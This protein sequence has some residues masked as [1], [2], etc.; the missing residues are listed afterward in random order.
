VEQIQAYGHIDVDWQDDAI[1]YDADPA[2][3]YDMLRD[4]WIFTGWS[5]P[6]IGPDPDPVW[7]PPGEPFHM[8]VSRPDL[9][10]GP[11]PLCYVVGPAAGL[12][13]VAYSGVIAL[14]GI[15]YNVSGCIPEPVTS[16]LLALGALVA[17]RRRRRTARTN[18]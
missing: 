1:L 5:D 4:S 13:P 10:L 14:S 18:A 9:E 2:A 11:T 7:A 17:L 16:T 15:D 8:H 3:N 6:V 12:C